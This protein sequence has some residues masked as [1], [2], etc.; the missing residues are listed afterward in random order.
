MRA[1]VCAPWITIIHPLSSLI[2]VQHRLPSWY[3]AASAVSNENRWRGGYR[4][5]SLYIVVRHDPWACYILGR[6]TSPADTAQFLG[7]L[8]TYD[9]VQRDATTVPSDFVSALSNAHCASLLY[10]F[11]FYLPSC[12]H[13]SPPPF[14]PPRTLFLWSVCHARMTRLGYAPM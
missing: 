3:Y 14:S 12:A 7:P 13:V 11:H 2:Q 8:R 9:K 10:R 4:H 6:R 5:C 1:T